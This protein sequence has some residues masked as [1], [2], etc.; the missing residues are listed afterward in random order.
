MVLMRL[1]LEPPRTRVRNWCVITHSPGIRTISLAGLVS[2]YGDAPRQRL[3]ETGLEA[4]ER[5]RDHFGRYWSATDVPMHLDKV[6]GA[7]LFL[8]P[9]W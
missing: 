4:T 9:E 8:T 1:W 3:T 5:S 2:V 7:R 6:R